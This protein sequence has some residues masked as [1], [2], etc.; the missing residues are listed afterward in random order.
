MLELTG[1][2][3]SIS[4]A[5]TVNEKLKKVLMIIEM[6]TSYPQYIQVET[7]NAKIEKLALLFPGD[8]VKIKFFLNGRL[9]TGNDGIQKCFTT[10]TLNEIEKC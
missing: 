8:Q 2:I 3:H 9:W 7:I 4:D 10:L 6:G 1:K 5:V